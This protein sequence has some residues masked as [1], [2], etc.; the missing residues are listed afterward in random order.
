MAEIIETTIGGKQLAEVLGI[1]IQLV[2]RLSKSETISPPTNGRWPFPKA[3]HD[4]IAYKS[5]KPSENKSLTDERLRRERIRA[6]RDQLA[7][8]RERGDLIKTDLAQRLWSAVM[9]NISNRLDAIPSKLAPLAHGLTIPEIKDLADKL[10]YE[11]KNEIAS[12]DLSQIA[13][14]AGHKRNPAPGKAKAPVKRK[15]V[16]GSKTDAKPGGKRGTRKV[17]HGKG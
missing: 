12:P 11:V 9:Q 13:R 14:M 7:L 4:Y 16:G 15:R 17:V 1:T 10:I 6:D 8:D 2:Y 5:K 3:V